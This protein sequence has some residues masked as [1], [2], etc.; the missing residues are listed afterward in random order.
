MGWTFGRNIFTLQVLED[1][2]EHK[3]NFQQTLHK[4]CSFCRI[5]SITFGILCNGI[6]QLQQ[7]FHSF[8][9]QNCHKGM[10]RKNLQ[11]LSF[12]ALRCEWKTKKE[13][14]YVNRSAL[15]C[16]LCSRLFSS[17]ARLKQLLFPSF[18]EK[19]RVF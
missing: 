5:T 11:F 19:T 3:E 15:P 13:I 18:S 2:G 6:R 14:C 9:A 16:R 10:M 4:E 7:D 17:P 12:S 8:H 1:N